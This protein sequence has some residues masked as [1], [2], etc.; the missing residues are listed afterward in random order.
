MY[1]NNRGWK[2]LRKIDTAWG[3]GIPDPGNPGLVRVFNSDTSPGWR[4][5]PTAGEVGP[6]FLYETAGCPCRFLNLSAH[7]YSVFLDHH[8]FLVYFL[9]LDIFFPN[10]NFRLSQMGC[11]LLGRRYHITLWRNS[12]KR[13]SECA[14]FSDPFSWRCSSCLMTPKVHP[15]FFLAGPRLS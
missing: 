3:E 13:N 6:C 10:S 5:A 14:Q 9:C 15:S 8:T 4:G 1:L 11:V 7:C 12:R 2:G